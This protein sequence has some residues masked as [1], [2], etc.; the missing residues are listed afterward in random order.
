MFSRC[1]QK[2]SLLSELCPRLP[3]SVYL[4]PPPTNYPKKSQKWLLVF[5]LNYSLVN[6]IMTKMVDQVTR[7]CQSVWLQ[8]WLF[9]H[10]YLVSIQSAWYFHSIFVMTSSYMAFLNR[11]DLRIF[12]GNTQKV[13]ASALFC[14]LVHNQG[15][16]NHPSF[17]SASIWGEIDRGNIALPHITDYYN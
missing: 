16:A 2:K 10:L 11:E 6:Q 12:A 5:N 7:Y 13:L 3:Y 8:I 1:Y 15:N 9:I 4:L 14:W 17:F